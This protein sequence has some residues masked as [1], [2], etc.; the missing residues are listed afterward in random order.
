MTVINAGTN[1]PTAFGRATFAGR[2]TLDKAFSNLKNYMFVGDVS[3]EYVVSFESCKV[4]KHAIDRV[5]IDAKDSRYVETQNKVKR[6]MLVFDYDGNGQ[7]TKNTVDFC[8]F[9]CVTRHVSLHC[10]F[11][12]I[13]CSKLFQIRNCFILRVSMSLI[14]ITARDLIFHSEGSENV[15]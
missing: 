13:R 11:V 5:K 12:L 15:P 4:P 7:V 2:F 1:D 3:S 8:I 14:W 6:N 9:S 10:L